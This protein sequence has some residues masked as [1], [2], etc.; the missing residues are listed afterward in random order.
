MG[1][2]TRTGPFT[3]GVIPPGISAAFLNAVEAVLARPSGD[4]ET[5]KYGIDTCSYANTSHLG[6]YTPSISRTSV[7]VS[8]SIDSAD[9]LVNTGGVSTNHLT[10]NGF[11]TDGTASGPNLSVQCFGNYTINY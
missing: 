3:D 4:T 8:V 1:G 10:A 7:P 2:Y 11:A 5:G 6:C 9:A